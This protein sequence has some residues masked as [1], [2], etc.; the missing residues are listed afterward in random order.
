MKIFLDTAEYAVIERW[1]HTGLIDGV[2]TNPTHLSKEGNDPKAVVKKICHLLGDKPVSVEVTETAPD[3]IYTQAQALAALAS[4]VIVKIPCHTDYFSVIQRLVQEKISLNITLVF[5]LMQGLCVSKLGVSYISPFV[6]RLDDIDAN[7]ISL[8]NDLRQ[9]LDAYEY[10]TELLAASL[11]TVS[12]VH[13]AI[14]AEVDAITLPAQVL[15]KSI[16]HPL[17]EH[18]MQLFATD[19]K[20]LGIQQFP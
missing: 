13:A 8:L 2:T 6:G 14:E 1:C 10:E 17:T 9:M 16:M 12:Q 4:N 20:K 19:W 7:G 18:G 5:T 11:R 15:E 3:K